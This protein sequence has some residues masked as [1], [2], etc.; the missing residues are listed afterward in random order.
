MFLRFHT[1]LSDWEEYAMNI[2]KNIIQDK[3]L[4]LYLYIYLWSI[5]LKN[6]TFKAPYNT[7]E[8]L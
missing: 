3:V 1:S 4:D 6:K 7:V 8:V 5:M 2:F